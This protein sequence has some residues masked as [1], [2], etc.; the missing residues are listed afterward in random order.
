MATIKHD[1]EEIEA[2]TD[3]RLLQNEAENNSTEERRR[4]PTFEFGIVLNR[5]NGC[6]NGLRKHYFFFSLHLTDHK[7][8]E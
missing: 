1:K 2:Q 8:I 7:R 6:L 3:V 4:P 5:I